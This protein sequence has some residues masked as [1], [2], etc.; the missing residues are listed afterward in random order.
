MNAPKR[1]YRSSTSKMIAGVSG[2]LAEY[3]DI[4]PVI[5]R[6]IFVLLAVAGG[7]S[8]IPIYIIL[9]IALPLRP[10]TEYNF[11]TF[12]A[13]TPAGTATP[14]EAT[15]NPDE[16]AAA[17]QASAT[18]GQQQQWQNVP[19]PPPFTDFVSKKEN[20]NLILGV[21]LII[22]GVLFF[23]GRFIHYINFHTLWPL[24]LVAV[25]A[26]LIYSN[27]NEQKNSIK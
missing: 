5:I 2:G 18:E 7:G 9:W 4:D 22:V 15:V 24:A 21:G 6:L 13:S 16:T 8:G 26:V 3:F 11:H 14:N 19:P 23:A 12:N 20:T 27:L 10:I 17:G 1:L 25:G